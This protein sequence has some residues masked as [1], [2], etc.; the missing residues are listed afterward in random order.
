VGDLLGAE[1]TG[2]G[3]TVGW[4]AGWRGLDLQRSAVPEVYVR[5]TQAF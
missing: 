1:Q 5:M 2:L 3:A 4:L